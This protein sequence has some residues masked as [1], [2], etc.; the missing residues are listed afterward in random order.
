MITGA[1]KRMMRYTVSTKR[2]PAPTADGKQGVPVTYLTSLKITP[3]DPLNTD[4]FHNLI[5]RYKIEEPYR[6]YGAYCETTQDVQI[7]DIIVW[8]GREFLLKGCGV[9]DDV[10]ET[11]YEMILTEMVS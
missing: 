11:L 7:G 5:L 8:N 3:I 2:R 10:D 4:E 6:M 9:W 1:M